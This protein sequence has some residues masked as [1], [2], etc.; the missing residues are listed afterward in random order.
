MCYGNVRHKVQREGGSGVTGFLILM[1]PGYLI[2]AMHHAV[3][4]KQDGSLADVTIPAYPGLSAQRPALFVL[5]GG[6][7]QPH[8]PAVPSRFHAFSK[9][10]AVLDYIRIARDRRLAFQ[11]LEATGTRQA[12][13]S[14][15]T[16]DGELMQRIN[17][18]NSRLT[19]A[20]QRLLRL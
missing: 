15:F 13:G 3:W 2:E 11:E 8:D 4:R 7:V 9:H 20:L 6:E 16:F 5:D 14:F 18:L 1:I 12:D 10:P 19:P 17:V